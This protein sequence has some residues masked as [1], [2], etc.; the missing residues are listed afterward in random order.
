[1]E[2]QKSIKLGNVNLHRGDVL[3]VYSKWPSPVV[4]VADG[5]YG[6][7]SFPGDLRHPRGLADWYEPHIKAWSEKASPETTLWFFNTEIGWAYVHPILE[8][9]GW[10]YRGCSV[11]DKGIGHIAGNSNTKS[12]RKLPVVTEVF[13]HYVKEPRFQSGDSELSMQDWLR[14]EWKRTGLPMSETNTASGVKNA[15]SRKYFTPDHLWYFPPAEAFEKIAKYANNHG[16]NEGRPYF[17]IDGKIPSMKEWDKMRSKFYCPLGVTNVW[18]EPTVNGEERLKNGNRS[19]HINQ[20]PLKLMNMLISTCSDE[21]DPVWE[22]FGGLCTAAL[23]AHELNRPAYAAEI[24]DVFYDAAVERLTQYLNNPKLNL[25]PN[26][27]SQ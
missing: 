13:V 17:S 3:D 2:M 25:Q 19:V 14:F 6:I 7:S 27:L 5:P 18:R 26:S 24:S 16:K 10:S 15:A 12:L 1:M 21:G 20:K 11:W 8:K 9:Y 23:A 22:P 4:I